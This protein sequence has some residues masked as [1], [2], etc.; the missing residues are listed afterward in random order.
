M[1]ACFLFCLLFFLSALAEAQPF[2]VK[3][4]GAKLRWKPEFSQKVVWRAMRFTPL[5]GTGKAKGPF[6]EVSNVDGTAFWIHKNDVT[7]RYRC[8]VV[9]VGKTSLRKGPGHRFASAK[10]A[11]AEKHEAFRDLGGEDGW[12]LVQDEGGDVAWINLQETWKPKSKIR[13]SFEE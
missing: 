5:S 6:L 2:C 8:L 12:T 4:P 13:L 9:K 1:K 10:N 3:T 11:F 7:T